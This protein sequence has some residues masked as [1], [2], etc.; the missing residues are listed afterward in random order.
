[1]IRDAQGIGLPVYRILGVEKQ[2]NFEIEW[3]GSIEN[4]IEIQNINWQKTV[5]KIDY[6][7]KRIKKIMQNNIP[8]F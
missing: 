2:N 5:D 1:M 6:G 3:N 8:V 7:Y 4:R